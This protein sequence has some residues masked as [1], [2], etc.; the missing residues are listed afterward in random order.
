METML[1]GILM[2]TLAEFAEGTQSEVRRSPIDEDIVCYWNDLIS[3]LGA[4]NEQP[5]AAEA[6]PL[7]PY[8]GDFLTRS[9]LSGDWWGMR[10]QLAE[11]GVTIDMSLTQATQGI[12]H[13]ARLS[14][15]DTAAGAATSISC[16][17]RRN[18]A[19]GRE[20]F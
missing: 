11:K 6:A 9:T 7:A 13:A 14:A 2:I 1:A 3:N 16:W 17:T 8:S 5:W 19:Y 15:G 12:V 20:G 10:N 4:F 18:S